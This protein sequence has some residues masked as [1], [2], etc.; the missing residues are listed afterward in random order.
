MKRPLAETLE[1]KADASAV[2]ALFRSSPEAWLPEPA[3][4]VPEHHARWRT[5]LWAAGVGILVDAT[6]GPPYAEHGGVWRLL[7]W[8]P[9]P[10]DEQT[11]AV[12]QVAPT[13][14]GDIGVHTDERGTAVLALRGEYVPPGGVVGGVADSLGLQRVATATAHRFLDDVAK[15]LTGSAHTAPTHTDR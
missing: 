15:R 12:A 1:L 11:F 13:F 9:H 10:R 5:Y 8:D 7:R 6:V 2:T 3:S 14:E 4:A